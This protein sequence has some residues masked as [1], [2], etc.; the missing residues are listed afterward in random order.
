MFASSDASPD[1]Q[2]DP[3]DQSTRPPVLDRCTLVRCVSISRMRSFYVTQDAASDGLH[4]SLQRAQIKMVTDN[5]VFVKRE[6][7]DYG[8]TTVTALDWTATLIPPLT[9]GSI[10]TSPNIDPPCGLP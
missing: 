10:G 9:S 2:A 7:L 3:Y 5:S 8:G 6:E 4:G 1:S